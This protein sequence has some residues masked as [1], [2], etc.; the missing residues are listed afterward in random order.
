MSIIGYPSCVSLGGCEC[1]HTSICGIP[2]FLLTPRNNSFPTSTSGKGADTAILSA[3]VEDELKTVEPLLSFSVGLVP[4]TYEPLLTTILAFHCAAKDC[5]RS[6]LL[7]MLKYTVCCSNSLYRLLHWRGLWL[8]SDDCRFA[9]EAFQ[10]MTVPC[11]MEKITLHI[12]CAYSKHGW[13][14]VGW[15]QGRLQL[16]CSPVPPS[17]DA[18][19]LHSPQTTH[20]IPS[21]VP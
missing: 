15:D 17:K 6:D 7:Q 20:G 21:R 4:H 2:C 13:L 19:I 11:F 8:S 5:S 10:G 12:V 18:P 9:A 3:W 16:P 14:W 1:M